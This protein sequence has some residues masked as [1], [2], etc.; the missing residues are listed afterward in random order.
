MSVYVTTFCNF[1]HN[2]QTGRPVRHKCAVLHPKALALEREGK[3]EEIQERG[4]MRKEKFFAGKYKCEKCF[5]ALGADDTCRKCGVYHGPPCPSCR[6]K[7]YH[8]PECPDYEGRVTRVC[9]SCGC[10]PCGCPDV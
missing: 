4:G 7:G 3:F 10:V 8:A 9:K 1:P 5:V 6:R 2:T